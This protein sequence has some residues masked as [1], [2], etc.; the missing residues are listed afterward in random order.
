MPTNRDSTDTAMEAYLFDCCAAGK[1][2]QV[3]AGADRKALITTPTPLPHP[4]NA[5]A[6]L[7]LSPGAMRDR[8]TPWQTLPHSF[9]TPSRRPQMPPTA[10]GSCRS[11][12]H[13]PARMPAIAVQPKSRHSATS[14]G[15][16]RPISEIIARG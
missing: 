16:T 5:G 8:A 9:L 15:S 12:A 2:L 6:R 13:P 1:L 14:V 4:Y 7:Q 3:T 10:R 11:P